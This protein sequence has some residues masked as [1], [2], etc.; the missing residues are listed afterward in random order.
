M[1]ESDMRTLS[2]NPLTQ[3]RYTH[4]GQK[5]TVAVQKITTAVNRHNRTGAVEIIPNDD[6]TKG[7][8]RD[9]G[10][11]TMGA[12]FDVG[13]KADTKGNIFVAADEE[14]AQAAAS[15][16]PKD[17]SRFYQGMGKPTLV[18]DPVAA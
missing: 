3:E 6:T 18:Q 9:G 7:L 4:L 16:I 12:Y 5:H 17:L 10:L 2:S 13:I 15:G 1:F 8:V 11:I 14:E